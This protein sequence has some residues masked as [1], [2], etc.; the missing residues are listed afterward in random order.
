[1]G[2]GTF[3]VDAVIGGISYN[4]WYTS[5]I[6]GRSIVGIRAGDVIRLR[7]LLQIRSGINE[8]YGLARKEMAPVMLYASAFDTGISRIALIEPYSSY[9]SVVMNRFYYPGFVQNLV[10]GALTAY[11]LPDLTATLAPRQLI[12]AGTTD[13]NNEK[14]EQERIDKELAIL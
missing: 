4:M 5:T 8:I 12:I 14:K 2:P 9:R 6:I 11:D 3:Q 13:G 10:P 1:M 7:M